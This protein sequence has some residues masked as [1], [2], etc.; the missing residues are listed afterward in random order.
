[1]IPSAIPLALEALQERLRPLREWL[2]SLLP[3]RPHELK[4]VRRELEAAWREA[5]AIGFPDLVA[6]L[7]RISHLTEVWECLA[8]EGSDSTESI[9]AFC[10]EGL[11]R[12]ASCSA[13]DSLEVFAI[14]D[15]S[16][17]RW[18]D[19]LTLI[20]PS[21][22][23]ELDRA[24]RDEP[25]PSDAAAFEPSLDPSELLRL[26]AGT[27]S[28]PAIPPKPSPS[29][30]PTPVA[31]TP[32]KSPLKQETNSGASNES[33]LSL[34]RKVLDTPGDLPDDWGFA[35]ANLAAAEA[36]SPKASEHNPG[37]WSEVPALPQEKRPSAEPVG[38]Q[39]PP[40]KATPSAPARVSYTQ[41][42]DLDPELRGAFLAEAT[43]L[44]E[45][46]EAIVV[47]LDREPG[48]TALLSELGR[49]LHTLKGAAGSV[50]LADFA[51]QVHALED[52]IDPSAGAT[53]TDFV[54]QLDA[55]L[56]A[57]ETIIAGPDA[58]GQA[59]AASDD[60]P[61]ATPAQAEPVSSLGQPAESLLR[62]P[63]ERIEALMDLVSEL[64]ARR[65][66][67][68]AQV[69]AMKQ[70]ADTARACRNRLMT[71][72]ERLGD[73]RPDPRGDLARHLRG[74]SE[75][76]EDLA[77]LAQSARSAA[78]PLS[79]DGDSMARVSLQLWEHLQAIQ[80]VPVRGLFHRLIRV[81]RDAARVEGREVEVLMV[82]E[83]TG[84]DRAVQD[85][86]FEP[87]LHIVRNAVGHG[88]EPP[89][90]RVAKGKCPLG[91]ITLEARRE[92][93]TLVISVQDDGRGLDDQAILSKARELGLIGPDE[94]LDRERLHA[95][96][97]HPGFS[98]RN[99]ANQVSGRGVGMDVVAQ[100][101]SRLRGTIH[102][103]SERGAGTTF[104][105]RLPT[106]LAVERVLVV[107]VDGHAYALPVETIEYAQS[108]DPA[109][110]EESGDRNTVLIG[111]RRIPLLDARRALG[112]SA[113]A[114]TE[115]PKLLLV[116]TD[117]GAMGLL[118]DS[119]E[120]AR[121]LVIKPLGP[122][123]V[124]HPLV[125]GSSVL[126][127]GEVILILNPAPLVRRLQDPTQLTANEPA[128]TIM[129]APTPALVVDDSISVR[130]VA[131]RQLNALG[132]KVDEVSDGLEALQRLKTHPYR[133]VLTDLEMPRMDGF[134]LLAE[135]GRQGV[136]QTLPVIVVSTRSDTETRRRVQTLGASAF[137]PKPIEPDDLARA[138]RAFVPGI[139]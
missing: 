109:T 58:S 70:F 34:L 81:A 73:L 137:L 29:P 112:I 139:S 99:V 26:L 83:Q 90:E 59:A 41:I 63:T 8:D 18:G 12:L 92:A 131:A 49:C 1:M 138:V 15:E 16:S 119:I 64:I 114:R 46:I 94:T 91:C 51:A 120:G 23:V 118:V 117:G 86:A 100:E 104:T 61:R 50:G 20:D 84:L 122:L 105:M 65:G 68:T 121:E 48:S 133:L 76:V 95:L 2:T 126:M 88:I 116:R 103:A 97:F 44:L 62:I 52:S 135:L 38:S 75:Q 113:P 56:T 39:K 69:D 82:G 45:R 13:T 110:A 30:E 130:R 53:P 71:C 129:E 134:E 31:H 17:A 66:A 6:G 43:D 80:I 7:R 55:L 22:A 9:A 11:G 77:V 42:S 5:D 78:V 33:V 36:P 72:V 21:T 79:D 128:T 32:P 19:Y 108:F 125:S 101:V 74:L 87:L 127:T 102:I 98:T 57:F 124:G 14:V 60:V 123:L 24:Q 10:A 106:R 93:N 132:F 27:T 96:I 67:W 28:A 40:S 47:Q 54:G 3:G 37:E 4:E 85:K 89:D 136:Q 115:C 35:E 107:R 25:D 111:D